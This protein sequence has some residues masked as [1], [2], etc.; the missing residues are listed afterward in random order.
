MFVIIFVIFQVVTFGPLTTS[1]I[2]TTRKFFTIFFSVLIFRNP[3]SVRQWLATLLVFAGKFTYCLA[4][5]LAR[6]GLLNNLV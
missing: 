1:V 3:M 6:R 2:T 4:K 5:A